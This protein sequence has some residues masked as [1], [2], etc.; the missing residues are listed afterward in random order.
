MN[1]HRSCRFETG[2]LADRSGWLSHWDITATSNWS[3][4]RSIWKKPTDHWLF[5]GR[6]W[7]LLEGRLTSSRLTSSSNQHCF[8]SGEFLQPFLVQCLDFFKCRG[9]GQLK[10]FPLGRFFGW[11]ISLLS[12]APFYQKEW[13]RPPQSSEHILGLQVMWAGWTS[14][15]SLF[16]SYSVGVAS[17][18]FWSEVN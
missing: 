7:D 4:E 16:L 2:R 12:V 1:S 9:P 11:F 18:D 6:Y 8:N 15:T 10:R 3:E 13:L 14:F 5:V 17:C